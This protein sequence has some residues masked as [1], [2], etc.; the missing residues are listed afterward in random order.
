MTTEYWNTLSNPQSIL[1]GLAAGKVCIEGRQKGYY[2]RKGLIDSYKLMKV[3][4][5][6]INVICHCEVNTSNISKLP[7][8]TVKIYTRTIN[9][10]RTVRMIVNP[11]KLNGNIYSYS[12]MIEAFNFIMDTLE[13]SDYEIIRLDMRYDSSDP[14]SYIKYSKLHRYL[15]SLI[16]V[17][18]NIY[19]SYQTYNLITQKQLS[20]AA[21]NRS[22]EIE[23]YD[24]AAESHYT[25]ESC[26]RLELRSKCMN[27]TEMAEPFCNKWFNEL[28]G[29]IDNNN[30][31]D[32][33]TTFNRE[34]QSIY[35]DN[36]NTRPVRF[37]SAAEFVTQ[38][39][40]SIFSQSQL[41]DLY[42]NITNCDIAA[43]KNWAKSYKRRYGISFISHF[44]MKKMVSEIKRA[45]I[46]F[47]EN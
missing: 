23:Y 18:R 15:I 5:H 9:G 39:Q 37:R 34:L 44:E 24:K 14:E 46:V 1:D 38:Y 25:D 33:W 20:I 12:E 16:A 40:E 8:K 31:I 4:V 7:D 41:I 26:S 19:N 27:G 36:K 11:N 32:T 28:D 45:T 2:L 22:L 17:R 21:K 47:F 3:G 43:A 29:A 6:T 30:L 13:I 35:Q 42:R 10:K